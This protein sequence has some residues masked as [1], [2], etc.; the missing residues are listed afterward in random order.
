MSY[1]R[2]IN[3][4]WYTYWCTSDATK[5]EDEIF[6]VTSEYN[7]TYKEIKEN[8]NNFKVLKKHFSGIYTQEEYK[9][10]KS[11][12]FEFIK[13]VEDEYITTRE[14]INNG[15][16]TLEDGFISDL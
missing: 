3:S 7:F 11:Y 13:D 14:K 15:E 5:K 16:I 8:I 2:W 6:S 4:C 9:E 12:M 10:L 1:S